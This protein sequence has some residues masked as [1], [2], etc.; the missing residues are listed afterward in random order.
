MRRAIGS[1]LILGTLAGCGPTPVP[2][3][4]TGTLRVGGH[5]LLDMQVTIHSAD[6]PSAKPVG[7]GTTGT[8]GWFELYQNGAKGPLWLL[9]GDYVCTLESIGAPFEVPKEYQSPE[10]SPLKVTWTDGEASPDLEPP[11]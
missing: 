5:V 1:L 3:G 2:G 7:F 8:D 6:R 9:P 10:T 11:E 4:T